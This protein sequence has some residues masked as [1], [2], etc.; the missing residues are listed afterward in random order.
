MKCWKCN[1]DA[2][3]YRRFEGKAW[4][5]KHFSEQFEKKIKRNIREQNLIEQ[6]EKIC[7]A[8]SGGKDSSLT[9]YLLNKILGDWREI[10]LIALAIDEGIKDY[11]EESLVNA[12]NLCKKLDVKL[13]I[14]SFKENF[15][16]T[17][18]EILKKSG[19]IGAC[20]VCGVFRR[21][22]LNRAS[23]EMEVDKLAM[24]H[25]M[26][27][28]LQSIFMNYLKGDLNRLV[29]MGASPPVIDN[30]LFVPRIKPLRNIPEKEI[31]LYC[32]INGIEV[33]EDECPYVKEGMRFQIRNFLNSMEEKSPGIKFSALKTYD[34]LLPILKSRFKNDYGALKECKSCGELTNRKK[35]KTCKIAKK[36]GLEIPSN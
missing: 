2:V 1:K 14:E 22:L 16:K 12:K 7:V 26:D 29:R 24:G 19:E 28:E 6:K 3:I 13:R 9:L 25:N 15:G 27:D 30:K 21:W 8:L 5:G 23:R 11:R 34:K 10:E 18:D 4:C 36:F 17:L 35:C 20:T 33:Q 31:G 32:L